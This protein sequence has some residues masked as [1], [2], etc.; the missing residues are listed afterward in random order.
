M[1][2][3]ADRL[4]KIADNGS[5]PGPEAARRLSSLLGELAKADANARR[6]LMTRSSFRFFFRSIS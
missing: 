2:A 6:G 1:S 3:T 4:A 5:G